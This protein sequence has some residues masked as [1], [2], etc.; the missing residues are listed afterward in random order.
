VSDCRVALSEL[1]I[2]LGM[3]LCTSLC[4]CT[5]FSAMVFAVCSCTLSEYILML[6]LCYSFSLAGGGSGRGLGAFVPRSLDR[7]VLAFTCLVALDYWI[8]CQH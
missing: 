4:F 5:L 7:L 8:T 3:P 6:F 2:K 1:A